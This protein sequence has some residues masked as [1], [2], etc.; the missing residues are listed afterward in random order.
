MSVP[1][2]PGGPRPAEAPPQDPAGAASPVPSRARGA[3]HPPV[4][5]DARR[6]RRTGLVLLPQLPGAAVVRRPDVAKRC[7]DTSVAACLLV[8]LGPLLVVLAVL[9]ALTSP[10]P[11]LYRQVR[12]GRDGRAFVMWKFRSMY[13]DA[14][15][16]RAELLA[17]NQVSGPLFKLYDDPRVTAVGRWMRRYSLD[18]LPQLVNVLTG[19][20]SLVGPRPALPEEVALLTPAE[21]GRE[22]VRPGLT[23]LAQVNGRSD[24]PWEQAV[25]MD[26][27]YVAHRSAGLDLGIVLRTVPAVLGRR[28]AY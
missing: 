22:A 9:V 17:Q 26:L 10:G 12:V 11:V 23:G 4:R 27:H 20:M 21:R 19:S 6:G 16:R 2:P 15:L 24:L 25:A 5:P 28:G 8:L 13:R 18:E 1:A 14:D 3:P 7:V